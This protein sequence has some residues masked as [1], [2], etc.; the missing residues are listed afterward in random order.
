MNIDKNVS[1]KPYNT[2]GIDVNAEF[3]SEIKSEEQL[4]E[5]L[6]L[7]E[8]INVPKLIIGGGSN[9]L[10]TKNFHGLVLKISIPDIK[11]IN[12]DDESVLVRTG[13]GVTWHDLVLYCIE[14]NFGGIENLSLIPGTTGAAPIQNIG[15]YG[16]EL[17]DTFENLEGVYLNNFQSGKF[18]RQECRFGYRSSIF[19]NELKDKFILTHVS[20]RLCKNPK[21]NIEYGNVR[22]EIENMKYGNTGI[23][24]VSDVISKIRLSKLPDPTKIGNAGSFFK[25]PEVSEKKFN[26]LKEEFED[27]V[28]FTLGN[29]RIKVPAGWLIEA[30]G[31]KGKIV[32]NTGA[33]SMQALV[34]VNYGNASGEEILKL[35]KEIKRSVLHKFGIELNEEVNI[36]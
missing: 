24:E 28:G 22:N 4:K 16:Q 20:L 21:I 10:L 3:F 32:G 13:A 26:R 11:I 23:K 25:N 36:I 33:H 31:W 34:L 27:I 14:R 29:G 9:I 15:A 35:S 12:E 5:V 18:S 6:S 8:F 7:Q 1:L 2:F 17:K 19:K 30:C